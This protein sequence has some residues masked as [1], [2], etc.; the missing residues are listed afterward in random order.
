M[1]FRSQGN[2]NID[3]NLKTWPHSTCLWGR[4]T[5]MNDVLITT[6]LAESTW[7]ATRRRCLIG[8]TMRWDTFT[9]VVYSIVTIIT[10]CYFNSFRLTPF[11][12]C[13]RQSVVPSSSP[14]SPP[15]TSSDG[16]GVGIRYDS[17]SVWKS[18]F[19]NQY[20]GMLLNH[21]QESKYDQGRGRVTYN[22][23]ADSVNG[24]D[25]PAMTTWENPT[26]FVFWSYCRHKSMLICICSV[27]QMLTSEN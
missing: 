6:M 1:F 11:A 23:E 9:R 17:G 18:L 26:C 19:W 10:K 5:I 16:A 27:K 14:S 3:T 12:G 24:I 20:F 13:W 21:L 22:R 7:P 2:C 4:G 8:G 15:S 25:N